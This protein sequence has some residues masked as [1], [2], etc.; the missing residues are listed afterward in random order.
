MQCESVSGSHLSPVGDGEGAEKKHSSYYYL[1]GGVLPDT[2]AEVS[3]PKTSSFL[4][5]GA[6]K[7]DTSMF[8]IYMSG[9]RDPPTVLYKI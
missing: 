2:P 7:T 8:R 1:S 3:K 4:A 6:G 5:L 9:A